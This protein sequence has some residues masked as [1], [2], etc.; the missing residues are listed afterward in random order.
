MNLVGRGEGGGGGLFLSRVQSIL[1][2]LVWFGL[3]LY[4]FVECTVSIVSSREEGRVEVIRHR[5]AMEVPRYDWERCAEWEMGLMLIFF[6]GIF[7]TVPLL[8]Q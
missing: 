2:R 7:F 8:L 3:G 1:F 6:L 5:N 4:V